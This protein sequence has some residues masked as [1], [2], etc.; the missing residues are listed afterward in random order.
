M[1]T[2]QIDSITGGFIKMATKK[3]TVVVPEIIDNVEAFE[4]KM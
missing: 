1:G 4:A 3:E 2:N